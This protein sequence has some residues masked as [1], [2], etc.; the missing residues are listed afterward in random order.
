MG[1]IGLEG[2]EESRAGKGQVVS[3]KAPSWSGRYLRANIRGNTRD[4]QP[5]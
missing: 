1:G 5:G 4:G 2:V 3:Q